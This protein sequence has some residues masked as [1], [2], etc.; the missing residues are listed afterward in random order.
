RGCSPLVDL[1]LLRIRSYAFGSLLGLL[2]FAGFT[3]IFF[4]L[5]LYYQRGLD[6]SA[7][8]AGLAITPFA[9]GSA[10]A[11][12]Y[13]GRIVHRM[14]RTLVVIGISGALL[15][16]VAVDLVLRTHPGPLAGLVTA[17]PLLVA[18]T[19]GGFVI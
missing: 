5:A 13:S 8:Q 6:Y 16:L 4:V 2:Y 10:A 1:R 19:G 17:L 11:S 15:G 12:A 9:V 7:L 3:S 18:G 14:G